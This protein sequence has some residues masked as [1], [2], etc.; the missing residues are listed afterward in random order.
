MKSHWMMYLGFLFVWVIFHAAF[1]SQNGEEAWGEFFGQW[2]PPYLAVLVGIGLGLA[3]RSVRQSTFRFYLLAVLAA[4]SVLYLLMSLWVSMQSGHWAIGYWGITDHKMSLVFYADLLAALACAK[5]LDD[6]QSRDAGIKRYIWILCIVLAFYVA[7]LSDSLNGI[8]LTGVCTLLMLV[9]IAYRFRE[10]LSRAA[11]VIA[12]FSLATASIYAVSS[13]PSFATHW[14]KLVNNTSVAVDIDTYP[15][16][17]NF[18]KQGLPK[19]SQGVQVP[20]SLYLRVAYATAG[21]RTVIEHPWGYGVT[22]RAFE[23]LVQQKYPDVAIAN[24]HNGYIDLVCAVGFPALLLLVMVI[25]SVYKQ[26]SQSSSE[27]AR[28]AAWMIGVIVVHWAIDP[29]SR[30]HYFET[31]LF[32]V[33]LLATLTFKGATEN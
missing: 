31:F 2:F 29:I 30:D 32:M 26:L 23:R 28:P 6:L 12:V 10:K 21:L 3:S 4:P 20:E 13:S 9:V 1:L 33:G 18:S 27:W 7:I 25:A 19:N 11:I 22:R 24:S 14:K 15:N 8:L 16:W 5:L 17:R